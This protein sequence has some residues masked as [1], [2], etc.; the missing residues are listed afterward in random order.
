LAT[1]VSLRGQLRVDLHD[2]DAGAYRWSDAE[3]D[4]H[5]E[6]A[7]RE[8]SLALPRERRNDVVVSGGPT[9]DLTLDVALVFVDLV[10]VYAVEY[11]VNLFPASYVQFQ[12]WRETLTVLVD[13]LLQNGEVVRIYWGS[14]HGIDDDASTLPAFAEETLLLGAAGYAATE[15]SSFAT[16]RAN[17]AGIE[18]VDDYRTWG[19]ARLQAFRDQL[20]RIGER[21]R[22]RTSRL[23][24]PDK[25]EAH[26]DVVTWEP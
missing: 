6:R 23:Y 8:L 9:R 24:A 7:K 2:Q 18:A 20:R 21:A 11:P 19:N 13:K 17:V 12:T 25:V 5:L 1:L 16:N 14:L 4:R 15:W 10:K 3:L 26:G 22:I